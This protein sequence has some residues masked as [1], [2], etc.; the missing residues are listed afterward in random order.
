MQARDQKLG[1]MRP[2]GGG[3]PIPLTKGELTLGR[4]PTNDIQLDF[5]NVS[6]KHCQLQY[7]KGVWHVRDLKSTNGTTVNGQKVTAGEQAILPDDEFGVSGHL[8][9]LDYEPAAGHVMATNQLLEEEL[10]QAPRRQQRSLMELAGLESDRERPEAHQERQRPSQAE[11]I[12]RPSVDDEEFGDPL[13]ESSVDVPV[14]QVV[15]N[16]DDFFNM[17]A[18]DVQELKPKKRPR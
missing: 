17:I 3:D 1:T 13:A 14:P 15:G 10:D 11:P 2:L 9:A 18:E 12:D 6:G 4:R 7:I 16:D 5:E 8:F